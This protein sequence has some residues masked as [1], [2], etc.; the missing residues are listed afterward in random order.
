MK[1]EEVKSRKL[2]LIVNVC[3]NSPEETIALAQHAEKLKAHGIAMMS[4]SYFKPKTA[5]QM[6]TLLV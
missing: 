3:S 1:T 6:A 5:E 4:P 2:H